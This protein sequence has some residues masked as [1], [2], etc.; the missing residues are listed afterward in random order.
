MS[1]RGS[2]SRLTVRGVFLAAVC[3]SALVG[4]SAQSAV[5]GAPASN[6]GNDVSVMPIHGQVSL[7]YAGDL[8]AAVQIGS[9]GVLVVDTMT[10]ALADKLIAAVRQVAGDKPIRYIVNTSANPD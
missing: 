10:D 3:V 6:I 1:R 5:P 9:E 8:N 7:L 2:L 4:L